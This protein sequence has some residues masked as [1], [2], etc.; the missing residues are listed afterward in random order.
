MTFVRSPTITGD[1][2]RSVER[3]EPLTAGGGEAAD[4]A[5]PALHRRAIARVGRVVPQQPPIR[6]AHPSSTKRRILTRGSPPSPRMAELF[7]GRVRIHRHEARGDL[8]ERPEVV[9]MNSGPVAQLSRS[10]ESRSRASVERS[11]PGREHGAH[12]LDGA[13]HHQRQLDAGPSMALRPM[14]AALTLSVSWQSRAA[15]SPHP[16]SGAAWSSSP[17]EPLER[18]VGGDADR[19]GAGSHGADASA[20]ARRSTAHRPRRGPGGRGIEMS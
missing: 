11:P 14:A 20:A 19:A 6:F 3:L 17:R 2:H 9:V 16:R 12:R 5:G 10:E 7:G 4:G 15:A 1:C 13:A 8:R 18:D